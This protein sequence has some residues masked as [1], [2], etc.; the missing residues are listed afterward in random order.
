MAAISNWAYDYK[1]NARRK[2]H[3]PLVDIDIDRAT[4]GDAL[5]CKDEHDQGTCIL[6]GL[7]AAVAILKDNS[8][9]EQEG[10]AR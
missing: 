9:S 3:L 8:R 2:G 5:D 4:Y 6:E 10:C 7:P 1:F